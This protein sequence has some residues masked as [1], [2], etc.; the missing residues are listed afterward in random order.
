MVT[1]FRSAIS[2][3]TSPDLSNEMNGSRP[4]PSYENTSRT[5]STD[6]AAESAR[7]VVS[8]RAW[9]A[10]AGAA[11]RSPITSRLLV[12]TRPPRA[13]RPRPGPRPGRRS[14]RLHV[15]PD[16]HADFQEAAQRIAQQ[17]L[18]A[19][20]RLVHRDVLRHHD[21]LQARHVGQELA[22]L[23]EVSVDLEAV[24]VRIERLRSEERRVGK[25]GRLRGAT[26]AE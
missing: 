22:D 5:S 1:S 17:P 15:R 4:A 25:E 19:L 26:G 23:V 7:A 21:A 11:A 3:R 6:A 12:R 10:A 8:R 20:R 16:D 18:R 9:A 24:L 2:G 13:G 14:R